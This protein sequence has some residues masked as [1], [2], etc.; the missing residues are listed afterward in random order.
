[1]IIDTGIIFAASTVIGSLVVWSIRQ[2]GR[3]N[4]HDKMFIANEEAGEKMAEVLAAVAIERHE[5]LQSR[6][7]RI[8]TKLD[9][10]N[11]RTG[12]NA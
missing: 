4:G 3:I 9:T 6:L 8:E 12:A 1:M 7:V 5:A 2:E 11:W 10:L